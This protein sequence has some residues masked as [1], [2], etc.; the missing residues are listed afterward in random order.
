ML[1]LLIAHII[2][3]LASLGFTAYT[4]V[5]PTAN[6]LNTSYAFVALTLVS[7]TALVVSAPAHLAQAC[8]SGLIYTGIV[9]VGIKLAR[10]RLTTSVSR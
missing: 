6:K 9:L 4:L 10:G 1:M 5:T 3:A 8:V 7:G 2:I